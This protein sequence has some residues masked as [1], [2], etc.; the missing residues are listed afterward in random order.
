MNKEFEIC[1]EELCS[2]QNKIMVWLNDPAHNP[3]GLSMGYEGRA[4]CLSS[5]V[6]SALNNE[7]IGHTMLIDS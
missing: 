5:L 4:A 1:L 2:K 7:A 3:T 6:T